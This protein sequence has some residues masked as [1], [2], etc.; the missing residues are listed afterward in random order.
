MSI[1]PI[2]YLPDPILRK[3][4]KKVTRFNDQ[5]ESL[6][7]DMIDTM[8][9]SNGVGL[10]ANQI[11]VEQKICVIEVPYEME[12]STSTE[13]YILVNPQIVVKKGQR[14][15]EEGCL[16]IPNYRGKVTRSI[17]VRVRAQDSLGNEFKIKA[18]DNLLAQALEHEIDHLNGILYIDH[19]VSHESLWKI[20]ESNH[21]DSE[22][23]SLFDHQI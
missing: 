21:A 22:H 7:A 9:M 2:L 16:S 13:L 8:R 14:E 17:E 12:E 4:T 15:L 3:K 19:L 5:L 1:R 18:V 11:G 20:D 23:L 10:A 6:I